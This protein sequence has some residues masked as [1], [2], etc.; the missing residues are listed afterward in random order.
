MEEKNQPIT[1]KSVK[2]K[3]LKN[4]AFIIKIVMARL[5]T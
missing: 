5:M 4:R 2:L 3:F 1:F